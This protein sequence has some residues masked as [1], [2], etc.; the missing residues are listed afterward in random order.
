MALALGDRG[1]NASVV[2]LPQVHDQVKQGLVTYAIAVAREK[3]VLAY[4]GDGRNRWPAAHVSD[5]ARLYR[6]ALERS[7]H[8]ACYH[9]VAEEG[10]AVRDIFEVIGPQIRVPV[11]SITPDEAQA[12]YGFL[13][14]FVAGEL[15]ASSA[16]TRETLDWTPTGPTM[17]EGLARL[18]LG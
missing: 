12:Q 15:L 8:G 7:A 4:V 5:V 17:L 6:L 13:G 16:W 3:G 9:A 1:V 2:R 11:R 10:V 18:Q 14:A